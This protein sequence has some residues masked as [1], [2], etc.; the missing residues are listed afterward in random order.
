M[1]S[2]AHAV[3]V[4]VIHI[5]E[6]V[7][8][9]RPKPIRRGMAG[10]AGGCGDP[11]GRS[12][13]GQV[14]RHRTSHGLSALPLGRMAA[15]AIGWRL[16]GGDMAKVAGHGDVR[17]SQGKTGRA[18]IK[19]RAEPGCGRM[20][21]RACGR[22]PGSNVIRHRPAKGRSALPL[23]GVTTVAI[24]GQCAAVVAIHMA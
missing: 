20:A 1:A 6:I 18:V 2:R 17:A 16:S 19:D 11:D 21:G 10:R 14:I 13:G 22:I 9:R 5:P 12:V 15:V 4:A 8:H 7:S 23:C 3:C 24:G